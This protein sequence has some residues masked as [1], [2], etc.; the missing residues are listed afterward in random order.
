M[1]ETKSRGHDQTIRSGVAKTLQHSE[2]MALKFYQVPDIDE[3]LRRQ[4]TIDTVDQTARFEEEVM[5]E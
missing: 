2:E 5:D 1:I 4:T 3:A